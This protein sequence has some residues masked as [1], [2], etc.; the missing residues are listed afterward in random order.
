MILNSEF[1]IKLDHE[2]Y[3]ACRSIINLHCSTSILKSG[4]NFEN[5][6]ECLKADFYTGQIS[7][8]YC[9]REVFYLKKN[10][11]NFQLNLLY[12]S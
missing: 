1:D 11:N 8:P 12:F 7:D 10:K 9:A 6:L 4:G 5:V 3:K 2:L